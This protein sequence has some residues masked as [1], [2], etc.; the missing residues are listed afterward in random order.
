MTSYTVAEII[1]VDDE[2][3]FVIQVKLFIE[4][5]V[6][7]LPMELIIKKFGAKLAMLQQDNT[8]SICLKTNRKQ[9]SI[10]RTRHINIRHL[11]VTD[12][13]RSGEVV[14]IYHPTGKLVGDFLTKPLN[15]TPFKN[16]RNMIMGM[17]DE[18]IEY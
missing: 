13:V 1:G 12:K 16:H 6:V 14:T 4:Q 17:D 5:Q 8:S 15:G 2:M 11:Y 9:S 7:N 3:N 10:K 18:L